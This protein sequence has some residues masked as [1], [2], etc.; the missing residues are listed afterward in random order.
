MRFCFNQRKAAQA[1]AYLI[2]LHGKPMDLIVLMKSMYLADRRVLLETGHSMTGDIMTSMDHGPL[3]SR[4]YDYTKWKKKPQGE[5]NPWFDYISERNDNNMWL[6]NDNP[7][8]DSLSE[9]D[10]E[11]LR[12]VHEEFGSYDPWALSKITHDLPEWIDP[13]GSSI[14][15]DP[16]DILRKE[17]KSPQEI[18]KCTQYAEELYQFSKLL[19]V[20]A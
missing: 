19:S 16:A 12:S 2:K 13:K 15:I 5:D 18:E 4:I 7:P 10:M 8:F 14:D 20:H 9:Y 11:V 1:A 6:V 3:L 17:G